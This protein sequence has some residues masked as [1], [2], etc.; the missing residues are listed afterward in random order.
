[1]TKERRGQCPVCQQVKAVTARGVMRMHWHAGEGGIPYKPP[2][3]GSGQLPESYVDV[4]K[5]APALIVPFPGEQVAAPFPGGGWTIHHGGDGI[6]VGGTRHC[7]NTSPN[8]EY[9]CTRD[10]WPHDWCVAETGYRVV[11]AVWPSS[12]SK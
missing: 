2:C 11:V 10:N 4:P 12:N 7:P 5:V 3:N 6:S 8:G 9:I 1:M